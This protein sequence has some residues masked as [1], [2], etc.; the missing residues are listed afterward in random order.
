MEERETIILDTD[1]G[2]DI[3]DALCIAYL[4]RQGQ[5]DVAAV[6]T[7]FQNVTEKSRLCRYLF[8]VGG[9]EAIPVYTGCPH[10]IGK[11]A[12]EQ[13]ALNYRFD[14]MASLP[15]G[16]AGEAVAHIIRL[17]RENPGKIS[18]LAIGPL[19]NLALAFR[20]A[21]DIVPLIRRVVIM[22]GA[23]YCHR[24]E[25]NILCDPLAADVVF[26]SGVPLEAVSADVTFQC[27]LRL[28]ETERIRQAK[29]PL[30][31]CAA[32]L[33]D[34]WIAC[35]NG[36]MPILHDPLAAAYLTH[37]EFLQMEWIHSKV[38]TGSPMTFGMT[39]N[40]DVAARGRYQTPL[41]SASKAVDREA[42]VAHFLDVICG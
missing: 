33:M 29:H 21:P 3:D 17:V 26:S 24:I 39:L 25:W 32:Q 36:A 28:E 41:M 31:R 34:Q 7:V 10:P 9:K 42:F 13:K 14:A 1:I 23:F 40:L 2:D 4:L 11:Q 15:G 8:S 5:V 22:G 18:I 35:H 12:D 16:Q 37:P 19:T 6:T 38:E 30:A 27:R 20:Q